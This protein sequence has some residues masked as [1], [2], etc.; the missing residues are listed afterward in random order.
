MSLFGNI[1]LI[2][3]GLSLANRLSSI[4]DPITTEAGLVARFE[5]LLDAAELLGLPIE[6]RA[7]LQA[8]LDEKHERD[9]ALA[10]IR[11]A[12]FEWS[13]RGGGGFGTLAAPPAPGEV[14]ILVAG[15]GEEHTY[16]AQGFVEWMPAILQL[17]RIIDQL[18]S[19]RRAA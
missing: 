12:E 7:K 2:R 13:K 10:A 4:T 6:L 19:A 17:L 11:Y 15:N 18:I 3:D 14:V 5:L 9:L 16:D 1:R 8:A